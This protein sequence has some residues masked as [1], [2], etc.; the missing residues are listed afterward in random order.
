M[1][2]TLAGRFSAADWGC[3]LAGMLLTLRE[4]DNRVT[5]WLLSAT[6]GLVSVDMVAL[7]DVK[8]AGA[9]IALIMHQ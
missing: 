3:N 6:E 2:G 5:L 1:L 8:V 7:A 9:I 4:G